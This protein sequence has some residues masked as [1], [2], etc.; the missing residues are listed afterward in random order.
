MEERL[1]EHATAESPPP[2]P[3]PTK[4]GPGGSGGVPSAGEPAIWSRN[5]KFY[6][7]GRSAGLLS[8][9]ML[10]VA[11]AAGLL[12]DGYGLETAG[13]SMAFLVAPF[14]GLV[15]FGGVLADRFTAR[16][17]M[18]LADLAN[19]V[20]H[21]LLALLFI[22][23]IDHLWQL[24]AL[25]VVAGTANALFQPGAASTVPLVSRDVQGANGILRTSEAITGL[26][27]PALAGTLVGFGSTGWV[28]VISAV[29]YGTSALCLFVLKLGVVPA[30][31]AGESM[32]HNLA[33][34]WRE[35]WARSWLWG[36]IVI[37]MFYA[38]L[39]W[40]PQLSLAAGV[41]VPEHGARAFGLVNAA[42]GAGTIIGGLLAIRYKP[43]RPLAAGA[44]AMM[45]Y[46]LY[47]LGIVLG[48]P[49]WMLI[50]AQVAVGTG[51]GIW[52]VMWSTSVQTQV[53]GEMLNR[54][55]AYEVAGSV[56]MYPIGSALAGPAVGLF[57][58]KTVLMVGVVVSFL[59]A[60]ALLIARPIRE[61]RRVPDRL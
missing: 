29:A 26:G 34:G 50:A 25:L 31:P 40:G 51:I 21:V 56:G 42:L 48:W 44:V 32:W 18:I 17:M 54:I 52:G 8:W 36:V 38:V 9:A 53:P 10:P 35:F 59:T 23:G 5:F 49:V 4:D 28:M 57:S 2:P 12:I 61:L 47:P 15:L 13:Y 39:A 45:A 27:G 33:V 30:P 16:R 11:V 20:A 46:P 55:H 14:A 3:P 7:V 1:A 24:Y 19:L 58:T 6:F 37:W 41:I 60:S 43:E 22:H